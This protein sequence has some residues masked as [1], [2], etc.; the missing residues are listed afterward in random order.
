MSLAPSY[1]ADKRMLPADAFRDRVIYITEATD[2]V[3]LAIANEFARCG[4]S[5][6]IADADQAKAQA[7]SSV[8]AKAGGRTHA[9]AVEIQNADSVAQSF[10]AVERALGPINVLIN[11]RQP[12]KGKPAELIAPSEWR[13][14]TD[15]ILDGTFFCAKE[16][17]NRRLASG[18]GAS[19]VNW[20]SPYTITGGASAA[21]AEA[22]RAAVFNLTRS[23]SVE[24]APYNIRVNGIAPGYV[25]PDANWSKEEKKDAAFLGSTIPAGRLC[26]PSEIAWCVLY[27]CSPFASY[28]TGHIF[29]LDGASWQRPGRLPPQFEPIRTRYE[30]QQRQRG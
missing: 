4:A 5:V 23:L 9:V 28:L 2:N 25:E 6:V 8:V 10:D 30:R 12:V 7:A 27:T 1:S 16:L 14:I 26:T 17:A 19:I 3:G 22:A 21:H 18:D 24:W 20:C 11:Y 13:A 29:D 15:R